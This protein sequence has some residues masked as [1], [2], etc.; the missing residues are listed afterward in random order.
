MA[1]KIPN[2]LAP[3]NNFGDLLLKI[4]DGVG[5]LIGSIGAIMIIVAGILYLTSAGSTERMTTAKKALFYAIVGIAIGVSARLIV[6]V[7][8]QILGVP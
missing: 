2:P 4:A 8:K 6:I 7:I 3:I 5:I 1:V